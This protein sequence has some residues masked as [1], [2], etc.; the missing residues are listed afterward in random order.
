M[1]DVEAMLIQQEGTGPQTAQGRFL[2][3]LD[4]VGKLSIGYGRNL[5]DN[6]VS[7]VEARG[8]LGNDIVIAMQIVRQLFSVYDQLSRPRQLVLISMAYN[9]GQAKFSK[10]PRFIDAVH[11]G[12]WQT[13]AMELL[14]SKAARTDAPSRYKQLATMMLEDT[15]T[16]V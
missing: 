12:D 2:P 8:M 13:A 7:Q 11:R 6:G 3:Y 1:T 9:L 4:T 10:W 14:D 15:S 5:T 16:W